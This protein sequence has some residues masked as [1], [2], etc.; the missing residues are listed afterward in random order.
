VRVKAGISHPRS[1]RIRLG[2]SENMFVLFGLTMPVS[3][4]YTC[5]V[6]EIAFPQAVNPDDP[7][8]IGATLIGENKPFTL[9]A[10]EAEVFET[11]QQARSVIAGHGE[12]AG[13][14]L[15]GANQSPVLAVVNMLQRILD[16]HPL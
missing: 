8:S 4:L 12:S 13:D 7:Q 3:L 2:S 5:F 11:R 1:E 6:G 10:K 16:P 15:T 9:R 14:T